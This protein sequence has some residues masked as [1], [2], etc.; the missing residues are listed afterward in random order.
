MGDD[1]R[2]EAEQRNSE[3][4]AQQRSDANGQRSRE[5]QEQRS[6]FRR[7]PWIMTA[8]LLP[9]ITSAVG[10]L[11]VLGVE[12]T[13]KPDEGSAAPATTSPLPSTGTTP[14]TTSPASSSVAPAED[15]VR[16]TGTVNLTYLDLDSVPPKVLSSNSG[17]G[18]YVSYDHQH[19]DLSRAELVG[20]PGGFFTTEPT[21]AVWEAPGAPTRS[22]CAD[23]VSTQAVERLPVSPDS[24]YC[25]KTAAGRIAS[26]TDLSADDV[27][28]IYK[29]VV[30]VW[31]R[32]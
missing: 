25:V 4:A 22:G 28:H 6:W 13:V 31:V 8:L 10:G 30:T 14:S 3:P 20:T 17:A 5:P 1:N 12:L 26:L 7:H 24:S 29:A 32:K 9:T 15:E 18:T 2:S 16:W 21:I 19:D 27:N 11:V 23:L